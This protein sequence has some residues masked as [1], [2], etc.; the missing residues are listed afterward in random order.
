MES[1]SQLADAHSFWCDNIS[2]KK[3]TVKQYTK[4]AVTFDFSNALPEF[5]HLKSLSK[6]SIAKNK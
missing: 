1:I 3:E 4:K 2:R 5:F 6:I